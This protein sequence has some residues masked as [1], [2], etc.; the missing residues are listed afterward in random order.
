[1]H[2][3]TREDR[4]KANRKFVWAAGVWYHRLDA[5]MF[6][7]RKKFLLYQI[8][9]IVVQPTRILFL[10]ELCSELELSSSHSSVLTLNFLT[11]YVWWFLSPS[12][13][14]LTISRMLGVIDGICTSYQA[15]NSYQYLWW[16]I[17][18]FL[19]SGTHRSDSI[20]KLGVDTQF[21]SVSQ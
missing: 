8:S 12:R 15:L 16:G 21:S 2:H 6:E 9:G 3:Y 1:M 20:R 13:V 17:L 19:P 14:S 5:L 7:S 10:P 11:V 4:R 18:P